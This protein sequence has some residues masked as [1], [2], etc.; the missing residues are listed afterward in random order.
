MTG[1]VQPSAGGGQNGRGLVGDGAVVGV[2]V[3]WWCS[4]VVMLWGSGQRARRCGWLARGRGCRQRKGKED[5]GPGRH[6]FI[7]PLRPSG[8][9]RADG[10]VQSIKQGPFC[11]L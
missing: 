6:P 4:G 2:V 11:R 5:L 3:R 1:H 10:T 7:D 8:L 9:C